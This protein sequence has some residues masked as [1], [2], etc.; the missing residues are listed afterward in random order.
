MKAFMISLRLNTIILVHFNILQME[1][2]IKKAVEQYQCSGCANGSDISCFEK[3]SV[4][5]IGCGKHFAGTT[6]M[7]GGKIFLGMPKGFNRLGKEVDL[8]PTIFKTFS[9]A[10]KWEYDMWNIPV[11]KHLN[12]A[13]HTLVRGI[14]P[15]KNESFIHIYLEDC[16]SKIDCREITQS[17]IEGM[18]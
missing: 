5:G 16:I 7:P 4:A 3:S 11:W 6:M 1:K 12:E 17:E 2:E 15:R 9:S 18:D 8:K 14:M 13:G 10:Y